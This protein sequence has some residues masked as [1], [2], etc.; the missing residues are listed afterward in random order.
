MLVTMNNHYI[1]TSSNH[2]RTGGWNRGR[3][4]HRRAAGALHLR[5]VHSRGRGHR[6]RS[7]CLWEADLGMGIPKSPVSKK[8]WTNDLDDLGSDLGTSISIGSV[9]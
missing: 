3:C 9:H 7:R 5:L 8:T 2:Q 6:R 4:G 1:V